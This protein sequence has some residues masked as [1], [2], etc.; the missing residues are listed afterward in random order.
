M[1][2]IYTKENKFGILLIP[3][4]VLFFLLILPLKDVHAD[5]LAI[6]Q[7]SSWKE[8]TYFNAG[9]VDTG[10]GIKIDPYGAWGAS[11]WKTPDKTISAGSA[12]TSDG[13][14]IYVLRGVGDVLFWRYSNTTDTWET[15]A[16]APKGAYYG[17]DIQYLNG[18]IYVLFGG[19]QNSYARYSIANNSWEMLKDFPDLAYQGASMTTDGTDIFAITANNTQNLYKYTI[20]TDSWTSLSGAPATLRNGAD[21][22][23]INGYIYTPRG[24][25]TNTFYRY[26][27]AGNSWSTLANLPG[28]MNDDVDIT[29]ANGK[30]YVARQNNTADFYAYDIAS[31]TWSTLTSAPLVSRYAGVQYLESDGYVYFFRGNG[32]YR[33]WKYDIA[34][35]KF[36]GPSDAPATLSTGSDMIYVGGYIYTTRGTNTTTFYRYNIATGVWD[37]MAVAPGTFNDDTRGFAANGE[38]YFFRGGNTN[39]FYKYT[40]AS[41]TWTTLTVAPAT[42]RYG[43]ALAYVGGDYIY[44]TRGNG[45]NTFWRYSISED[46]WSTAVASL[47]TGIIAHYGATLLSDGTDIFFT[48]GL[49]I[50]RMFKYVIADNTWTEVAQLPFSPFYG[51]DTSYNGDGKI[52][53]LSGW[54]ANNMWEYTIATNTWRKLKPFASIGPTE[55]GSWTGASIVSDLNGSF[56]VSRGGGR[57]EMLVYTSGDQEY[58]S[59]GSWTSPVYDLTHV[60]SW[61]SLNTTSELSGDSS[62]SIQSRSSVDGVNWS[63]WEGLT[64]GNMASPARRYIQLK[65]LLLASSD[66]SISPVLKEIS[67]QY[68]SDTSNPSDVSTA[69]GQSQEVGGVALTSGEEYPYITPSFAWE[70]STDVDT[71]IEGY[72]VYFGTNSSA[73]P[74]DDGS[75]QYGTTYTVS[76][77][78]EIGSNYLR[79]VAKDSVGN[80][81]NTQNAFEYIYNGV[82]PIIT[83]DIDTE[84]LEGTIEGAQIDGE[85]IKLASRTN[86]FWLQERLTYS[87]V[88]LGYGAKNIAYVEDSNRLYI[89]S[90]QNTADFYTYDISLDIWTKLSNAPAVIYY[91]G[92]AVAGPDGSIYVMRG[93]NSTDFWKYD[94]SSDTW[95]TEIASA[96]LTVGYGGSMVYDGYQYLY[97]LR[98]NNSDFFWRY[99]TFTD[100]WESLAKVDFGAPGAAINN[101]AYV[102]ASLT[103]DIANQLI[104]A[105]QGNSLPGYSVYNIN[106]DSWTVLDTTPSLPSYGAG[107]AYDGEGHVYYEGGNYNPY[108][109][110]YDVDSGEWTQ[111]MST[112]YGFYYGGGL[113]KVGDYIYG[114]RGGNSNNIFKYDIE[115]DSWL[116]PKRGIFSREFEGNALLTTN[117]GADILKGDGNNFYIMRGNYDD[118]FFRWNEKTGELVRL[119]NLPMGGYLGASLVYDSTANKIYYTGGQYDNGFFVYDVANNTWSEEVSDKVPVA[120][121]AGSSMIYDGSR[122]IYLARASNTNTF[123]RF[124]PQGSSGSKWSIM[125]V[126]P[127]TLSYGSELLLKGDNIYTLRGNNVANN[128]FYKY[129]ISG[130]NWSSV[131]S[132]PSYSYNDG[133]LV[134]GN[135][136]SFYGSRGGNTSEFYKYT[137]A[138]DSWSTLPNIPAQIYNGGAAESNMDNAI[139]ALS[140]GGTNSYQDALYTYIMETDHSGFNPEGTYESE[141]HNLGQVYKWANLVVNYNVGDNTNVLIETSSSANGTAWDAW[142]GVSRE[143]HSSNGYS[144]KINSAVQQYL[145]VRFTLY[146]GDGINTPVINDYSINYYQDLDE[147]TNPENGGL[148]AKE[149]SGGQKNLNSNTWYNY[150]NPYFEWATA[151]E[152][153]GAS[154]GNNGSGVSGYYI[155]W[156]TEAESIPGEDGTFQESNNFSPANLVNAQTYH[157]RLQTVDDAGNLAEEIWEPFVYK[158]NATA[159]CAPSGLTADPSGYT[160]TNDF[161]FTWNEVGTEGAP[162]ESYCYKTGA[163][164]GDYSVEQCIE[165]NEIASIPS[166]KVGTNTFSVRAKDVAGNFSPYAN[167]TYFFVD[168][169]NAPAPPLNLRA[170]PESS[171][172]NSFGFTWDPPAVGTYYGSQSNL[173]Y[174][175]SVNALPT[176]YSTSTTS[177]RYL[178]PGAYATLPGENIFY[179]VTKDEAGNVNYSNYTSVSFFANTV[180]PGLPLNLE[181]ADVSVKNKLSWRL[182]VSWDAP[183]DA[184]SGIGGYQI[185]RSVDGET[186]YYHSFTSGESLVDSKL[187]QTTYYYKV[188]ACDSTNNCGAFSEIVSLFPDGRYIEPATLIIDPQVSNITPKKA[189]VSWVTAR[190][191]DSRIAYGEE[192]GVYFEEEVSNSEQVVD[193]TLTINNL[194]PGT[195]Y[196]YVAK[197]TDEDGNMGSS[198]EASFETAPPP[199]IEEPIVKNVGLNSALI[200]FKTK[201]TVKVKIYYGETSSFGGVLEVYTGTQESTHDVEIPDIKDGTK[202]FFKINTFDIDGSEY[203]GEIHS[204]E[205]LPKPEVSEYKI[206]QVS[207]TSKTVLLVEWSSNTPVSSIVTY[208]PTTNPALAEDE[209]N[210]AL[211]TGK[212][213]MILLD[214]EPN[215]TYSIIVKGR[216]FMGNEASSGV[217]NFQTASDT[218]PPKISDLEVN[219]EIIGSGQEATAQVMVSYKTDE[220][221]TAQIEYGEGTGTTY[222]QKTQEDSNLS[223]TH[224]VIISGLTP[225]KVYH[226]RAVSRDFEQNVGYSVDKVVVTNPTTANALDLAISNLTSIFSFLGTK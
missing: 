103:I 14:Y 73:N 64:G 68:T 120:V 59:Y 181:I 115:K 123:Y 8:G 117:Y 159:P 174:L 116:I 47:P 16:N 82:A 41:D 144:Y 206:Y 221:A 50:K 220:D 217:I 216:D 146:S 56:Y 164:T 143:V 175:Y 110:K 39:S 109:Y 127:A 215:T 198:I 17:S 4:L 13:T 208:Y 204:F 119:P 75:F 1:P 86:G 106:T 200:E 80:L 35:N 125:A 72:Y 54:Y 187:I 129:S 158:Y 140:G 166:Y 15:L 91:G 21:L 78:L 195:K 163:T 138:S 199:S 66:F 226:F 209:V 104:Y 92:G 170:T 2:R 173:S 201:D 223:G 135:N 210:V 44:A 113:H 71:S 186:F 107:L 84:D 224:I 157:L 185:Y 34:N 83:E 118:L 29:D 43:A 61:G 5:E 150:S 11:T 70:A 153:L 45:T 33:F 222:T 20:A 155:Y 52:L 46:S 149:A 40:I 151:G 63:G 137:I 22:E 203:E 147:P 214:L 23:A 105:I 97:V 177:L 38:I 67:L 165:E 139:Y 62:I 101:N 160:S 212:H 87:P 184:G 69:T 207:G 141:V 18:Y 148:N 172:Q 89:A 102:G 154:D 53:A 196:Y 142:S 60:S 191:A 49:G 57:Q 65:V 25:N 48:G 10:L 93:Y 132:F 218:R 27:I 55:I 131:A 225:S 202:Y 169:E 81:S 3:F 51:S 12:F 108:M 156:G 192:P 161:A 152:I 114:I 213:R 193:H 182:A 90:G 190:T 112:P 194:S 134:D 94:T 128:P 85:G 24:N 42:V 188:K 178:N 189:I 124:D 95:S 9:E 30:I 6:D 130:N 179:I 76:K 32:D 197:W 19:Y 126:A 100:I 111:V 205:T 162:I 122:Y 28:T 219:S 171:T 180:A 133:F 7:Q 167:V 96:P 145:K 168:Y 74:V 99:D 183:E 36:I 88:G 176:S 211:K 31:N 121:N 77:G 98:G 136:G 79:I 26:D 37:T 58:E